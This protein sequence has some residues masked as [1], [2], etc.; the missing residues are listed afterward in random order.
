MLVEE[1]IVFLVEGVPLLLKL[2]DFDEFGIEQPFKICL[3][4]LDGSEL[5]RDI[6]QFCTQAFYLFL[7]LIDRF[8]GEL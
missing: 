6:S 1:F 7:E 5:I 3:F 4:R 2:F 8:E